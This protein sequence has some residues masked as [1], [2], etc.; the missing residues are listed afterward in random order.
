MRR[1]FPVTS[2]LLPCIFG[3]LG[4]SAWQ[5]QCESFAPALNSTVSIISSSYH[6]SGTL[7]NLTSGA[8]TIVSSSLPAFCRES[9]R[10]SNLAREKENPC[11]DVGILDIVRHS[12]VTFTIV[13]NTTAGSFANSEVW[14]PDT[15][16]NRILGVGNG[17]F[18]GGGEF[19][20]P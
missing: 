5:A 8:G 1:A 4:V 7:V 17:G 20:S 13:T 16:N 19:L 6:P 2:L 11:S 9:K 18:N 14:L 3:S 12:G 10:H 15:W